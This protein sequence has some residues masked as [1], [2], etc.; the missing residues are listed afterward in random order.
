MSESGKVQGKG[1][2]D[3]SVLLVVDDNLNNLR[4]VGNIL[5]RGDYRIAFANDA[6]KAL[7]IARKINPDLILLDIV[8]PEIDG[9][10]VCRR[11]KADNATKDI[12][13]IFLTANKTNAE[14][15]VKG[16]KIGAVDYVAKPFKPEELFVR[17]NTHLE[18]KQLREKLELQV[19]NRTE[20]LLKANKELEAVNAAISIL[21]QKRENDRCALEESIMSNVKDLIL[22]YIDKLKT[23]RLDPRQRKWVEQVENRL[24]ELVSP[25]A[26]KLS[27]SLFH[28]TPA[29][30]RVAS[31]IKEGKTSKE[32]ADFLNISDSGVIFHRNNIRKK[33]KLV[34]KSI[35]LRSFLQSLQ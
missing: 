7:S 33:L 8:M 5:N 23:S 13:V 11:L 18:L 17:I 25:F 15:V 19:K 20:N 10:E 1:A 34:N 24:E 30:I 6:K 28:L 21:L 16:F 9:F 12:P 22:P 31:L 32:I 14:D 26:K 4:V 29:E 35:N 2:K 27:S 3:K